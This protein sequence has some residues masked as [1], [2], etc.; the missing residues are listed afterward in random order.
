MS[1][2]DVVEKANAALNAKEL[3][4]NGISLKRVVEKANLFT[5]FTI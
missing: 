1:D 2:E 5:Y 3:V 4:R